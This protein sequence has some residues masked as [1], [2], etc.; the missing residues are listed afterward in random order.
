MTEKPCC[1]PLTTSSTYLAIDHQEITAR[2]KFFGIDE[3]VHVGL[4]YRRVGLE[5][6][7]YIDAYRIYFAEENGFRQFLAARP[8]LP[9]A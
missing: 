3:R 2:R 4:V 6:K 9:S 8:S 5:P 1:I 7:W